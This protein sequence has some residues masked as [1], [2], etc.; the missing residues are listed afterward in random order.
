MNDGRAKP[1]QLHHQM[2][3]RVLLESQQIEVVGDLPAARVR[4][5][6][7]QSQAL[8]HYQQ[9][10]TSGCQISTDKCPSCR[11]LLQSPSAG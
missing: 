6:G 5:E 8:L 10:R 3:G 2:D 7:R 4:V 9:T 1:R 11:I